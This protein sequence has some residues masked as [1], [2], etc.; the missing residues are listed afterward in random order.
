[1]CV[2]CC[3]QEVCNCLLIILSIPF[4]LTLKNFCSVVESAAASGKEHCRNAEKY[5]CRSELILST[6]HHGEFAKEIGSAEKQN[7]KKNEQLFTLHIL[8]FIYY[9]CSVARVACIAKYRN[10]ALK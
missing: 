6:A 4:E 5:S 3:L 9:S 1:M 2:F 8:N 7:G 10:V